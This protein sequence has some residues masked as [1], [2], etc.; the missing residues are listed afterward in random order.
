[1]YNLI[2]KILPDAE[3]SQTGEMLAQTLFSNAENGLARVVALG[4][5]ALITIIMIVGFFLLA[6]ALKKS[7]FIYIQHISDLFGSTK[8]SRKFNVAIKEDSLSQIIIWM[9]ALLGYS[10]FFVVSFDFFNGQ[11]AILQY[12]LSE[13]L[14]AFF[15][16]TGITFC[17]VALILFLHQNFLTFFSWLFSFDKNVVLLISNSCFLAVKLLGIMLLVFSFF[18]FYSPISWHIFILYFG[19]AIGSGTFLLLTAYCTGFFFSE[20]VSLFYFFLYLCTLEIL[21][22]LV[23]KKLLAGAYKIV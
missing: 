9:L 19:F 23:L 12:E 16:K 21:P 7:K 6:I 15:K 13:V 5:S 4:N 18:F 22:V 8:Y 10:F 11:K 17:A 2:L 14:L 1:M 3:G 20:I